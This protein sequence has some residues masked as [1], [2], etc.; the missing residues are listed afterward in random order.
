MAPVTVTS[1]GVAR[2]PIDDSNLKALISR[3]RLFDN[4]P[5]SVNTPLPQDQQEVEIDIEGLIGELER[6]TEWRYG[7][8]VSSTID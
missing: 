1:T 3:L 5:S 2:H 4:S 8:L 6:F 7:E